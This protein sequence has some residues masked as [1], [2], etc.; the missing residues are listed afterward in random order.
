MLFNFA[1]LLCSFVLL[2]MERHSAMPIAIYEMTFA[3]DKFEMQFAK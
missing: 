1:L 3:N 2:R